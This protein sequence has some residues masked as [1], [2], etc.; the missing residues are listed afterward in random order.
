R[1]KTV[2][3][4]WTTQ[5][6]TLGEL[7]D[8]VVNTPA[9]F[10]PEGYGNLIGRVL[11]IATQAERWIAEA[12]QHAHALLE[13]GK[14]VAGW[15]LVPKRATRRWQDEEAAASALRDAGF[16]DDEIYKE[17]MVS[18]AAIEK[19]SHLGIPDGLVTATSSGTTLAPEGDPRSE[20]Q[21]L[22]AA[23]TEFAE[24]ADAY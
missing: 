23:I 19:I 6:E 7:L 14:P 3:P 13:A 20:H 2:C 1:A 24:L 5:M 15:K 21:S 8:I 22:E 18:P 16:T 9:R 4:A 12:R 17:V 10:A 11:D